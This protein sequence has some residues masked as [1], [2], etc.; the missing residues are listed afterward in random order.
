MHRHTKIAEQ[1]I[2]SCGLPNKGTLARVRKI[3]HEE[4]HLPSGSAMLALRKSQGAVASVVKALSGAG[5][6]WPEDAQCQEGQGSRN[7]LIF[8]TSEK[9]LP[10]Q[11]NKS[12]GRCTRTP[13]AINLIRGSFPPKYPLT[14]FPD[15]LFTGQG[16]DGSTPFSAG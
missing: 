16:V 15:D 10:P 8:R 1:L 7:C 13:W 6:E 14:T 2:H 12:R 5:C 9:A 11:G 3:L 4:A